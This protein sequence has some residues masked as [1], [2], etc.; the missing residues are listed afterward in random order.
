[1]PYTPKGYTDLETVKNYILQDIDDTFEDQIDD[2]I[3]G[4]ERIIDQIT[5]RNFKADSSATAR[6][7]DG[8]DTDKLLI[9]EAIAVTV[10]E[11][12]NDDYGGSFTTVASSG[13]D[14]YY[15]EP[16]NYAVKGLPIS[17]VVLSAREWIAGRQNARITA[18]W[19]YSAE[20]PA[21]IKLVATVFVAGIINQHRQGGSEIKSE[22]IGNYSVTY[23]SDKDT[24]TWAD[25]ENAKRLLD[26][27]K[28]HII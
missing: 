15:L 25:F 24:N 22:T 6:V 5:G 4:V 16:N 23:N 19:G 18:K 10:V 13:A 8:D 14:R 11:V 27:Y 26:T 20:V 21:D 17:A 9:D 3:A 7:Y 2:W 12:G 28:R 1:M